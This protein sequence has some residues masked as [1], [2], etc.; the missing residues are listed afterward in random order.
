MSSAVAMKARSRSGQGSRA[1]RSPPATASSRRSGVPSP[2]RAL[3][4]LAGTLGLATAAMG[5]PTTTS[6]ATRK[7]KNWFQAAQARAMLAAA[8]LSE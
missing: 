2:W 5:L 4:A 1:C 7:L 3:G 8:W 6:S